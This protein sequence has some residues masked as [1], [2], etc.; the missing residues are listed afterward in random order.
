MSSCDP[1]YQP[2]FT[3]GDPFSSRFSG[4]VSVPNVELLSSDFRALASKAE[5]MP[6]A[7]HGVVSHE[8]GD[9]SKARSVGTSGDVFLIPGT[10]VTCIGRTFED[11]GRGAIVTCADTDGYSKSPRL[12]FSAS[13]DGRTTVWGAVPNGVSAVTVETAKGPV[14]ALV[15]NNGISVTVDRPTSI[16]VEDSGSV[17]TVAV[18][19]TTSTVD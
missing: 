10:K 2:Y 3:V 15:E 8:I 11:N 18:P 16:S 12:A 7:L 4:E 1:I 5:A 13:G 14:S 19:Q 9:V 6:P 17:M